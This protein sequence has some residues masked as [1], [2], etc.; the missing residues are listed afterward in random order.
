MLIEI[1]NTKKSNSNENKEKKMLNPILV[2]SAKF[3]EQICFDQF[4]CELMPSF[5]N[6]ILN[7]IQ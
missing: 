3:N 1:I 2:N 4:F 6:I 7:F 5:Y